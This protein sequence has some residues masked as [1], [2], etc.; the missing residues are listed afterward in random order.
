VAAL[1]AVLVVA[2]TAVGALEAA[3]GKP[4][5]RQN[6]QVLQN[7]FDVVDVAANLDQPSGV[8]WLPDGTMLVIEKGG[9]VW[10]FDAAGNK[11]LLLDISGHVATQRERGLNGIA[12]DYDFD[13]SRRVYLLYAYKANP[14]EG[15]QG[16]RLT[17]ITLNSDNTVVN[18]S[19]PETVLLGKEIRGDGCPPVSNKRDCPPSVDATHQGGTIIS[20]PDG[21]LWLG[22]GDSNLPSNPGE[23]T[24]R[25]YNPASTSGKILHIDREGNGL[26]EH[27]F[28]EKTKNLTRTCTKVYATGF[29]NPFRFSLMPNGKPI[30]GDVGWN[31]KEEVDIVRPGRNYGWPCFEGELKTPFYSDLGRC[32]TLYRKREA[33]DVTD[34]IYE[35]KNPVKGFGAAVIVGPHYA[36]GPYPDE[37]D[38]GFFIADYAQAFIKLLKIGKTKVR[39]QKLITGIAPVELKLAPDGHL[40]FVDYITGAVRK[41]TYAP[42]NKAPRAQISATPSSGPAGSLRVGFSAAGS[43]DPDGDPLT[44]SWDFGDGDTATGPTAE[45]RYNRAGTY[46]ATLTVTDPTGLSD[47]A[48]TTI[49]V[50]NAAP[51]ATLQSPTATTLSYAGNAVTMQASGDDFEDGSLGSSHFSWNVVLFHK[52]HQHPLGTFV[53]NPASFVAVND[54][55]ADSFYQVTL[56]VTDSS[57]LSTKLSPVIVRPATVPLEIQSRP[58]GI[59]LSYGGRE[60]KAPLTFDAAVGFAANLSAP[61]R[62]KKDD[63]TYRFKRWSQGGSRVQNYVVPSGAS[64][65]K[66]VYKKAD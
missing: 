17:Y 41:L 11:H 61:A 14:G 2:V 53:G 38:G 47:K 45:H 21:T 52:E 36:S 59:K 34:P 32:K 13:A 29:R 7:Q 22:L 65:I 15:R 58:R 55:D 28:C 51:F 49:S 6:P 19:S 48:T 8:D 63:D 26:P 50:G 4:N 23:Q 62:V 9:R 24:F 60:M 1:V 37:F 43:S 30:V 44:Y 25:T 20:A 57:G 12:V 31:L 66:A 54:H 64:R 33:E 46:T 5:R 35:Y 3:Q 42:G 10:R 16:M 18:P 56:T 39:T 27:P 40:V